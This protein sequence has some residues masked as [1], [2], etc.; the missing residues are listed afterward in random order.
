MLGL[1]LVGA[2]AA[3]ALVVPSIAGAANPNR[4]LA[5]SLKGSMSTYY[6]KAEPGL[7]ITTVTCKIA[8]AGTTARCQA[9]FTMVAKRAKG[10]FQLAIQIDRSTGGV[11]THTVSAKCADAKTNRA[12]SC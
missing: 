9:K 4:Q 2:I 1:R 3:V 7:K 6:A 11:T 12:I 8:A 10:V 5:A